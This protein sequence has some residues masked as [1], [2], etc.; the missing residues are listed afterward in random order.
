MCGRRWGP[1]L[2]SWRSEC[3]WSLGQ[4]DERLSLLDDVG[5]EFCGVPTAGVLHRVDHPGRNSEDVAG[6]KGHR[7]L[8]FDLILQR[9]LEDVDD[10]FPRMGVPDERCFR[11]YV[12]ARLDDLTSGNA[13]IVL[14]EIGAPNSRRL[15][16]HH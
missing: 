14:L 5:G 15:V 6:M 2:L 7:R 4:R 16:P 12:D 10:L 1:G 11:A 3:G 8:A 13:E 9:P